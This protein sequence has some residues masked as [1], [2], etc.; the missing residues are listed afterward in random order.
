MWH[1][2]DGWVVASISKDN[3]AFILKLRQ[4]KNNSFWIACPWW[5]RCSECS[6]CWATLTYRHS[7]TS[8]K[9]Y[10]FSNIAV[11]TWY[12]TYPCVVCKWDL[13]SHII[14]ALPDRF[15]WNTWCIWLCIFSNIS[16]AALQTYT[17]EQQNSFYKLCLQLLGSWMDCVMFCF[18]QYWL[19]GPHGL[20]SEVARHKS[21][22]K[23]DSTFGSSAKFRLLCSL[24]LLHGI[25]LN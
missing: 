15:S 12:L 7:V 16:M 3:R 23:A 19:W 10:I 6:E 9:P 21:D 18:A 5:W 4:F 20:L 1:F 14:P 13:C 25:M 22:F 11:S 8:H 2:V 24:M 17:S